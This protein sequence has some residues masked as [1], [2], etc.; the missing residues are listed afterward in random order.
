[1][2]VIRLHVGGTG[3]VRVLLVLLAIEESRHI[4]E[5]EREGVCTKESR[6]TDGGCG[7]A[8]MW[9]GRSGREDQETDEFRLDGEKS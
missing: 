4:D 3:V 6:K 8:V 5:R 9:R 1:M 7:W 2:V